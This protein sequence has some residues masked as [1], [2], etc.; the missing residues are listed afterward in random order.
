MSAGVCP[1]PVCRR[2]RAGRGV[3]ERLA[4]ER[5][6]D[7]RFSHGYVFQHLIEDEPGVGELADKLAVTQQAVSKTIGELERLGYVERA[8]DRRDARIHRIRLTAR[9]RDAVMAARRLRAEMEERLALA[10]G[11]ARLA[12]ARDVLVAALDAL[13]GTVAVRDREVRPPR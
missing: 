12:D 11:R 2:R 4:A 5:Y 13:G 3:Q 7:L 10:V 8:A 6:D 1:G 9:G